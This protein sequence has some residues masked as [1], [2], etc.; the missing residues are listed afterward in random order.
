MYIPGGCNQLLCSNN[1][2]TGSLEM[3][4]CVFEKTQQ[5]KQVLSPL[6]LHEKLL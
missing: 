2:K 5:T 6:N 3:I 1:K 4:A